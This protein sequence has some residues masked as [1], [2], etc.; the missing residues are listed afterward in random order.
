MP[1]MKFT[2]EEEEKI[3]FLDIT[4]MKDDK[5]LVFDT[6]RKP[7]TTNIIIPSDSCHPQEHKLAAIRYLSNRI[8]TYNLNHKDKEKEINKLIQT[9][10]NNK[11]DISILNK[12]NNAGNKFKQDTRK[13]KWAKFKYISKE[14][15]FITN[16]ALK[17]AFTTKK[18]Y[19]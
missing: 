10:H 11:Y 12:F 18:Q 17:I 6:Y 19:R 1:T 3:K 15:K 2:I 4:I 16:T 8:E 5:N 9:L 14:T 13:T 7:T